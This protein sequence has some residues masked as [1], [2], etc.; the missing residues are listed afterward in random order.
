MLNTSSTVQFT[1]VKT[2]SLDTLAVTPMYIGN[3]ASTITMGAFQKPVYMPGNVEMSGLNN[4]VSYLTVNNSITLSDYTTS[5]IPNNGSQ[6]GGSMVFDTD[7][8]KISIRD[9]TA[10]RYLI[11]STY[12]NGIYTTNNLEI[13]DSFTPPKL[14]LPQMNALTTIGTTIFNTNTDALSIKTTA[15]WKKALVYTD[16]VITPT[17]YANLRCW[18][19]ASDSSTITHSANDVTQW[20]DKSGNGL[21][22]NVKVGTI[23][24]NINTLNGKNVINTM[25]GNLDTNLGTINYNTH[26]IFI[27]CNTLDGNQT[28]ILG[29]F[30]G[31]NDVLFMRVGSNIFRSHYQ[32]D[33]GTV[34]IDSTAIFTTTATIL[35][36]KL[37]ATTSYNYVDTVVKT[38]SAAGARSTTGRTVSVGGRTTNTCTYAEILIYERALSDTEFADIGS[39]LKAKWIPTS[40]FLTASAPILPSLVITNSF[41]PPKLTTTVRN[42]LTPIEG[43]TIYNTTTQRLNLRNS[44]RWLEIDPFEQVLVLT[45]ENDYKF[46]VIADNT[47]YV[48]TPTTSWTGVTNTLRASP[49]LSYSY[50]TGGFT[51]ATSADV[52]KFEV[53]YNND[54][55]SA[56]DD[57]YAFYWERNGTRIFP[58][59]YLT[60]GDW[61]TSNFTIVSQFLA[62]D[63]FKLLVKNTTGVGMEFTHHHLT[64]IFTE[65]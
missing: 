32:N 26:T 53:N 10:W 61:V 12:S 42:A 35:S 2:T 34:V 7:L 16:P 9:G 38:L 54:F 28:D 49:N 45:C 17:N 3:S 29:K 5:Q 44:D 14:T 48:I 50:A 58:A 1:S 40:S 25:S 57:S 11:D 46:G 56:G 21:H 62:G 24:T 52:V 64:I 51:I 18:Y 59:T 33:G 19:D 22:L 8:K 63:V 4:V 47:A 55:K 30:A 60:T 6:V 36:H 27:V 15:G 23:T 20:N 31:T 65:L 43:M 41:I 13:K 37:D 39:Y